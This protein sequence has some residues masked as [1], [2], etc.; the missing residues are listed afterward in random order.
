MLNI[1]R[2]LGRIYGGYKRHKILFIII[3]IVTIFAARFLI[4]Y[5][6]YRE[7]RCSYTSSISTISLQTDGNNSSR[8]SSGIHAGI[9]NG[10]SQEE[11]EK[12]TGKGQYAGLRFGMTP[13]GV[14]NLFS[15][16]NISLLCEQSSLASNYNF[17]QIF[18]GTLQD[19]YGAD[20]TACFYCD[21]KLSVIELRW[22]HL[23]SYEVLHRIY[24]QL[25][26]KLS[27]IYGYPDCKNDSHCTFGDISNF[28]VQLISDY[29]YSRFQ[30]G[31]VGVSYR[32]E[33]YHSCNN[34]SGKSGGF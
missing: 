13:E 22:A 25:K 33:D 21:E 30:F 19:M 28:N 34:Q 7:D 23:Q 16:K 20:E 1:M 11:I 4:V 26:E 17:V 24:L 8:S 31:T 27:S 32:S 2:F 10:I 3:T 15:E 18:R 29:D 14:K 9:S 6:S 12:Q 5:L